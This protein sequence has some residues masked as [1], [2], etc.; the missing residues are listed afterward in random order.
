VVS[1]I[2]NTSEVAMKLRAVVALAAGL[3]LGADAPR[4]PEAAGDL[5]R[6]R[7]EWRLASTADARRHDPGND[8][9]RMTITGDGRVVFKFGGVITNRGGLALGRAGE[10][11]W[12]DLKLA[13]G[14]TVLAV[15]D[16]FGDELV[17]CCDEAGKA[18]PAGLHPVGTQWLER[19][20]RSVP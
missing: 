14:K 17:I 3:F 4:P 13:G 19:W 2:Q 12:L 1:L 16:C 20:R 6:L 9:I 11:R 7:G 15:Y 10:T 18:R 5:A 8:L